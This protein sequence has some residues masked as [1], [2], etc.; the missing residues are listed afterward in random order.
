MHADVVWLLLA[1]VIYPLVAS[2]VPL[3]RAEP[4]LEMGYE[5]GAPQFHLPRSY[6]YTGLCFASCHHH[7]FCQFYQIVEQSHLVQQFDFSHEV[8]LVSNHA[9]FQY[10][11][12]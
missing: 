7:T 5:S 2:A 12:S 10:L 1:F 4:L 3:F 6:A 8:R 11:F 9:V